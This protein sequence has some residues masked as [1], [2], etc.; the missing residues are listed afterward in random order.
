MNAA[1]ER[2]KRHYIERALTK[3]KTLSEAANL[4]GFAN[5]QTLQNWI[6]K[7]ERA[8]YEDE[9]KRMGVA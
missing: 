6:D 3:T 2:V 7:L 9:D 8:Q 5:Y 4:L 1:L